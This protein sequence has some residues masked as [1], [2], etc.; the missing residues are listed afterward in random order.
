MLFFLFFVLIKP[1]QVAKKS[2]TAILILWFNKQQQQ[3][4]QNQNGQ[5]NLLQVKQN[6]ESKAISYT[7]VERHSCGKYSGFRLIGIGFCS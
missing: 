7:I 5:Q 2:I 4:Q 3:Q 6:F 1:K